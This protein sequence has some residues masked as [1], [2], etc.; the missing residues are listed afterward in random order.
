MVLV[1]IGLS[2][3][4]SAQKALILSDAKV[5]P[6]AQEIAFSAARGEEFSVF[7]QS[8]LTNSNA[9]KVSLEAPG[10]HCFA[11]AY[12]PDGKYLLYLKQPIATTK[13]SH[14]SDVILYDRQLRTS[15]PLTTGQQNIREALFSADGKRVVYVAAGFFGSYSP[16]GPKAAHE[17]DL[18]S[19]TLEGT[20]HVQHSHIKAYLLGN[21]ALLQAPN[22]YL[23]NINHPRLK[24]MGTYAYS[25]SDSTDF[26]LVKDKIADEHH[27]S[28]LPNIIASAQKTVV[29]S[30]K[31]EL[32][33]K[34]MKNGLSEKV[35]T[36]QAGS[37]PHPMAFLGA[38]NAILFS[39]TLR[40][41]PQATVGVFSISVLNMDDLKVIQVPI[42]LD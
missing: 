34:N 15:R 33:V 5:A 41:N 35:Y 26:K 40:M 2:W 37:N 8:L 36:G 6:S 13:K 29:Y 17:L 27:L 4:A 20:D 12:S 28:Y 30:I 14:Y 23:L 9:I 10:F 19:M 7:E 16:V 1:G 3:T 32:F 18:H 31:D 21:L 42:R 38:Q 39:E 24:L 22:T 25:L 11:P